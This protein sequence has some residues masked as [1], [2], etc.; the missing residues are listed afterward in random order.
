MLSLRNLD[1]VY[2]NGTQALRGIDLSVAAGEAVAIIGGS[3]SGKSTLLRLVGGLEAATRGRVEI[4]G[5]PL[6]G[7][8]ETVGLVFQEPRLLPWLSVAGNVAFGLDGLPRQERDRRVGEVLARVGLE[9]QGGRWPK[10]LSGGMAQR[11]A[12]ARTLAAR[13]RILL[14]D[15]PFSALDALTRA[16]LQDHVA[17][18][19]LE[20]RQTLLLVT[21]DIEEALLLADRVVILTPKPGRIEEMVTVNLPRPRDRDSAA[22]EQAKRYLRKALDR[23]LHDQVPARA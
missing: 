6:R 9:G 2:A 23:S 19:W 3:G 4:E 15:E 1:K 7:P 11:V 12:L 17:R 5:A 10:E 20:D 13:P 8:A 14:L 22:F 18:L 21:H 16:S